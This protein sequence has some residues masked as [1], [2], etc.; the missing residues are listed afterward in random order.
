MGA[1]NLDVPFYA[2]PDAT[3][4][5]QAALRMVVKYFRPAEDYSWA[6]LDTITAKAEGLGAWPFAGLTWLYRQGFDVR[7]IE[8]MDNRRFAR[9]GRSYLV[10]FF[11]A[12]FVAASPLP[13]DLSP[14][15]AAAASFVDTVS[16]ETRIPDL[17]DLRH[18]LADGYL[19]VCNVNSRMLNEREG[20]MGHFV[21]VTS[22]DANELVLHDPGPPGTPRRRVAIGAFEKAWAYPTAR[23][24]NIV[25]VRP[26]SPGR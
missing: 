25:A 3:H 11:G 17:D 24:K 1:S 2:N 5:F 15:Q 16:C 21:V 26:E 18:L 7:N 14:E 23:A 20:Y 8:L 13:P 22:C 12:E 9:E 6:Q 4:C 10:E 19:A